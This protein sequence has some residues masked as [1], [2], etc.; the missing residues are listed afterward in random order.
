MARKP[1]N[2]DFAG[3][4]A[5]ADGTALCFL[6]DKAELQRG[7]TIL[8]N[9]ASGAVGAAAVQLAVFL[10]ARVTGSAAGRTPTWFASWA[11]RP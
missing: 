6:R 7:Q 3:A 4:A 8:I 10:G 9:G 1:A 5:L 11:R 2:V